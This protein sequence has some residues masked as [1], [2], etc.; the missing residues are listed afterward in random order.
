MNPQNEAYATTG[1][2]FNNPNET[3]VTVVAFI[4]SFIVTLLFYFMLDESQRL[5]DGYLSA[6]IRLFIAA[7]ILFA[8][9]LYLF[10]KKIKAFYYEK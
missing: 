9:F 1:N 6:F 5:T 2:D 8:G 10:I 4:G 3:K 7:V